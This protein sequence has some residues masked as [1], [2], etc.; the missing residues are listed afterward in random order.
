[1]E[2]KRSFASVALSW[3]KQIL[4]VVLLTIIISV[5]VVQTYDIN[6]ISMEP[7]FDPRGNRV[8]VFLAPYHF[9]KVPDHGD[10]IIVDSRVDQTRTFWDKFL[11][12]PIISIIRGER[13]EHLW[14]KRT[15]GLPGDKLEYENG[16]VIRNGETLEEEYV[17]G[18]M[19][20]G[21]DPVKV[22]E[23]HIFV[24]GDNRNSSSDSRD[25]GPIPIE[26]IQGRVILRFFPFDKINTY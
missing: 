23:G 9:D 11:E 1:M 7:T 21:F 25:I 24:M 19:H 14:V 4:L 6:D 22:P 10:I 3:I 17:E 12:S 5:L 2:E 13:D 26:N 20:S 18:E 8:L 16:R 15:I